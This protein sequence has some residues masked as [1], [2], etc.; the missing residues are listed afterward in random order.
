M[1][2]YYF[3]PNASTEFIRTLWQVFFSS[4]YFKTYLKARG[5]WEPGNSRQSLSCCRQVDVSSVAPASQT[6]PQSGSE[7]VH[8]TAGR[9]SS[10]PGVLW[11]WKVCSE[12]RSKRRMN[13]TWHSHL[14]AVGCFFGEASW[15]PPK[16][17]DR[18]TPLDLSH[19]TA[20]EINLFL[21]VSVSSLFLCR[22]QRKPSKF[23][24]HW[25]VVGL[26][27]VSPRKRAS[28]FTK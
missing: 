2:T 9:R 24:R 17:W 7:I 8:I 4:S 11:R 26:N 25:F 16:S 22:L 12:E 10:A 18:W 20:S 13:F 5:P 15:F 23:S 21:K 6:P 19:T 14:K 27:C 1:N 28:S 3:I